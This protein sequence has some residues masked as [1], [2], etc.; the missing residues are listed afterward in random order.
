MSVFKVMDGNF[1]IDG[2]ISAHSI[3]TADTAEEC[4]R[5]IIEQAKNGP[6]LNRSDAVAY[7][8]EE[9]ENADRNSP[10]LVMEPYPRN[11]QPEYPA[12][13]NPEMRKIVFPTHEEWKAELG[14]Q[15]NIMIEAIHSRTLIVD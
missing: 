7:W 10:I 13:F 15:P 3:F 2:L 11:K 4:F 14:R 12:W 9:H 5:Y 8:V 6:L 1:G